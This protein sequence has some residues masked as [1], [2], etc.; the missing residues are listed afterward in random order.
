M[1][2]RVNATAQM[3]L[4]GSA[5]RVNRLPEGLQL[6]FPAECIGVVRAIAA[7]V[8]DN[9][10]SRSMQATGGVLGAPE[11]TLFLPASTVSPETQEATLTKAC[12][13]VAST[14]VG[15]KTFL[16][17]IKQPRQWDIPTDEVAREWVE[18]M[19]QARESQLSVDV[20]V[21]V[22]VDTKETFGAGAGVGAGAGFG[23]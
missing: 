23:L 21:D 13:A 5:V 20:G 15:L 1:G 22:D 18:S 19:I 9:N 16:L 6:V 10:G 11:V 2:L 12:Q 8:V 4:P 14:L 7:G 17:H 3:A